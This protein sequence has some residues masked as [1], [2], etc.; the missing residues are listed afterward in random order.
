VLDQLLA[1]LDGHPAMLEP[2]AYA[3]HARVVAAAAELAAIE[4]DASRLCETAARPMHPLRP[5]AAAREALPRDAILA[6]DVGCSSQHIAGATPY[7]KVYGPRS[8]IVPSSFYGMG[9]VAAGLPAARLVHPDRPALAFVGDGSFQMALHVLPMAAEHRLGVT[10]CVLNDGALGSIRDIQQ[11]RFAGRI[12]GTE[13]ELQPD[14]AAIARACGCHGEQVDDPDALSAALGRAL[15]ANERGVPAVLDVSV[16]RER[17]L[18]TLEHYSFY[19]AEL[20]EAQ[21]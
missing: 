21:A 6:V 2:G 17:M 12:L 1:A 16:S 8:T 5:I 9:F 7:F 20:M 11:Y 18:G 10:W 19:P 14:L 15:A 13:F 3:T 4:A